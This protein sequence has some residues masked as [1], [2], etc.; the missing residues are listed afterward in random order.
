MTNIQ[1]RTLQNIRTVSCTVTAALNPDRPVD[2]LREVA[3]L[4]DLVL[5]SVN[6]PEVSGQPWLP[7]VAGKI[8]CLVQFLKQSNSP[9]KIQF[10]NGSMTSEKISEVYWTGMRVFFSGSAIF[11]YP[12]SLIEGLKSLRSAVKPGTF[13]FLVLPTRLLNAAWD[14]KHR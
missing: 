7:E 6:Y 4:L 11:N 3:Q 5:V 8:I 1:N 12:G 13:Q 14:I 9:D 10:I 2:N